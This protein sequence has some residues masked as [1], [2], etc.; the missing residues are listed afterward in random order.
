PERCKHPPE[1][2][3]IRLD[4]CESRDECPG[5]GLTVGSG[6]QSSCSLLCGRRCP[7]PAIRAARTRDLDPQH[8]HFLRFH[9]PVHGGHVACGYGRKTSRT[10]QGITVTLMIVCVPSKKRFTSVPVALK[11]RFFTRSP[12]APFTTSIPASKR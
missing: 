5:A 8:L 10:Y 12:A 6:E 4:C 7:I 2:Y 1:R 3:E 11:T 9:T